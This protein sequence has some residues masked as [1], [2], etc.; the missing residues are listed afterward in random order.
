MNHDC[1][2]DHKQEEKSRQDD[3]QTGQDVVYTCPMHPEIRQVRP[4]MCPECGMNL[5]PAK[6]QNKP[7]FAKASEGKHAG[8]KTSSFLTKFWIA[9]AL[10]IPIFLYSEIAQAIGIFMP[11]FTGSVMSSLVLGSIVYFYCGWT[12]L[13]SAYRELRAKL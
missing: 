5:V 6:G 9:L 13:T 7:S 1:C 2:H 8:H 4:G 12:F 11:Q 10:T 3:A